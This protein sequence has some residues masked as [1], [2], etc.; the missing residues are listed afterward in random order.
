MQAVFINWSIF[1]DADWLFEYIDSADEDEGLALNGLEMTDQPFDILAVGFRFAV[2][3]PFLGGG[4]GA[5]H[6]PEFA[7]TDFCYVISPN[8]S[9]HLT[10][11]DQRATNES[12]STNNNNFICNNT[13]F[14]SGQYAL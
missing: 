12:S 4:G 11:P 8:N 13:H 14:N 3:D 9:G 5:N 2:G 10:L 6:H 7:S 1:V